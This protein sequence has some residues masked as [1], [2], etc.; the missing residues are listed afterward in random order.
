MPRL[1]SGIPLVGRG[2]ETQR[3]RAA[4]ERAAAGSGQALLIAGDAGVGKSR[5][6]EE[7]G[8]YARDSGAVV[9]F[10]RCVDVGETG[11]PY[12]PF[13]EALS[14]VRDLGRPELLARPSLSMLL[15]DLALPAD[16]P[17]VL[18]PQRS[19]QAFGRVPGGA[20]RREQD[21]SQLR[22]FDAVY[23]LLGELA[24]ENCVV[25]VVEDLHWADGST[26]GLL[27]FLLSRLRSQRL[28]VVG[29]YRTDDLH[30]RH[31][32]RPLLAELARLPAVERLALAPFGTADAHTFI[33]ALAEGRI[34]D[35]TVLRVAG[36]SEGNAFFAEE[37]LAAFS[38]ADADAD[39]FSDADVG[40]AGAGAGWPDAR[41]GAT[42]RAA[43]REIPS[44][45]VDVLLTRVERL[46]DLAQR[47]VRAASVAGRTVRHGTLE[48]VCGLD[49]VQLEE[50]LREA[51]QHHVFVVSADQ[52]QYSFRH[53]LLREA[54]YG[55]LLP[56]ER[57]RLHAAYAGYLTEHQDDR[58]AAA[59][60]AH[61]SMESNA[62]PAALAASVRAAKEA[63]SL[64]A[65]AESLRHLE[66]ALRLWDTAGEE[67]RPRDTDELT[68]LRKASWAAGT[69]GEPERAVAYARSMV[70][71]ADERGDPAV[72]AESRRRLAQAL[73]AIEGTDDEARAVIA[74]A[75]E[76]MAALPPSHTRAWV[77]AVRARILRFGEVASARESAELAVR[78]ARVVG[79]TGAESD[80]LATLG[81]LAE[82]DG[83]VEE[84]RDL[85]LAAM[86]RA[87]D[88][89]AITVEL[90]AR[91]YL[92]LQYLEQGLLDEAATAI[93]AGVRCANAT[94]LPWSDFGLD[95]RVLQVLTRFTVGDW[96]AGEEAAEQPSGPVSNTVSAR[97]AAAGLH[98]GV[99]RG[100]FADTE[101]LI[102]N[103]RAEWY[104]EIQIPLIAGSVGA[105]LACWRGQPDL[106]LARVTET[107]E[108]ARK[109]GGPWLMAGIRLGA[110]GVSACADLARGAATRRDTAA[111]EHAIAEGE[112]FA[113]HARSTAEHGTPRSTV[114]G[115][116]GHGWL[117]RSE[118]ELTRLR[119]HSDPESWSAAAAAFGYGAVYEQ[120]LCRWRLGEAL[121]GAD[122]RDEAADAL[123]AA[124]E[125][126]ARLGAVPLRDAIAQ[127]ARRARI[128]LGAKPP[129]TPESAALLT[130]REYA[131]LRLVALGKTNRQVGEELFISDKTA[132]V[133]LSHIMSKLGASRRGEAVA[134]AYER[135]LL[136]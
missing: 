118:A 36:Q 81:L 76:G 72:A 116:E 67:S 100:R 103:L 129:A 64:G 30:R 110:L 57:V 115:P 51:V 11:L 89:G 6:V 61:H 48:E 109:V 49:A 112:R 117:A 25:L 119:G 2:P 125:V 21:V 135:G 90:R 47:V 12:L 50:A 128:T 102:M 124:D 113:Q 70:R 66:Q 75:W 20:P 37:L 85:L 101:Q 46:G 95:L 4:F 133:H 55:D 99:G 14:Q 93:D 17:A 98:I 60:L 40:A 56:G 122:R 69:S 120:A 1:G 134:I 16:D 77:L 65:P 54:V 5:L 43:A 33:T 97:L 18:E 22:L 88:T 132:S 131:V 41:A 31:P 32:L 74:A 92:G 8:G 24:A 44:T 82:M 3:L 59:S 105:E 130:P 28:L 80:A 62:L 26:R 7:L 52:E 86:G 45:L 68:L 27:S 84:S 87:A 106:A 96:D 10:G 104:R 91:Y 71:L 136:G 126:A 114:L 79:A 127:L 38:D 83:G 39:A 94:G 53:A 123:R 35:E 19:A 58:G 15:P 121:L 29:T 34:D 9:L 13:A 78:D 111:A 73:M 42:S 108:W 107:L 23:A 63:T